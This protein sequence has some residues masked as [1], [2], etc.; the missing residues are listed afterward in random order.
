MQKEGYSIQI[1][2]AI[3]KKSSHV[4]IKEAFF[5]NKMSHNF[6]SIKL[7]KENITQICRPITPE[8]LRYISWKGNKIKAS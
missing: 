2:G 8:D 6:R 7:M 4:H 3:S 1:P 5:H